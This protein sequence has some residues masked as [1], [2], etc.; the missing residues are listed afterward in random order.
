MIRE[1]ALNGGSI[2]LSSFL[3]LDF[4]LIFEDDSYTFKPSQE[5]IDLYQDFIIL[6]DVRYPS[7]T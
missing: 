7:P 6:I 4:G 2:E 1:L 3:G 5:Y